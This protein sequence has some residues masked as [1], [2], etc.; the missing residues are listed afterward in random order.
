VNSS[1]GILF[2]YRQPEYHGMHWKD[3]AKKALDVMIRA[4]NAAVP[5]P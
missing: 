3:A 5:R 1:R 2:A 4:V